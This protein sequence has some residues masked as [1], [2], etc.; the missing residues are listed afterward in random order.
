MKEIFSNAVSNLKVGL[1][2]MPNAMF[3]A[4]DLTST[5]EKFLKN[6]RVKELFINAAESLNDF[7]TADQESLAKA[8]VR[9]LQRRLKD[10]EIPSAT[11]DDMLYELS[12][13]QGIPD[14][15][16]DALVRPA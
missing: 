13:T 6:P 15:F 3:M 2:M 9:V 11:A 14:A 8:Y 12:D 16:V 4:D 1:S 7:D 10:L 5:R